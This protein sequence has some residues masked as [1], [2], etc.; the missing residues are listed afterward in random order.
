LKKRK[1]KKRNIILSNL[2]GREITKKYWKDWG[3]EGEERGRHVHLWSAENKVALSIFRSLISIVRFRYYGMF[4]A[5]LLFRVNIGSS[6]Y[7]QF[8]FEMLIAT[9]QLQD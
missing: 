5:D 3:G 4:C 1:R 9:N 6:C 7:S 2:N 8:F